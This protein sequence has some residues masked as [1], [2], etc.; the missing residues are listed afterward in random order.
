[1][2]VFALTMAATALIALFLDLPHLALWVGAP[3]AGAALLAGTAFGMGRWQPAWGLAAAAGCAALLGAPTLALAALGG[4]AG[5]AWGRVSR[6]SLGLTAALLLV[7]AIGAVAALA[8]D[9]AFDPHVSAGAAALALAVLPMVRL[10]PAMG[11]LVG[12]GVGISW[13]LAG[14]GGSGILAALAGAAVLVS[15]YRIPLRGLCMQVG[16]A[17][18]SASGALIA[19]EAGLA[20]SPGAPLSAMLLVGVALLSVVAR[21]G[22]HRSHALLALVVAVIAAAG[23]PLSAGAGMATLALIG[24][25]LCAPSRAPL[26]GALQALPSAPH[27]SSPWAPWAR[28][29]WHAARAALPALTQARH[30]P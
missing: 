7:G 23:A 20:G 9:R 18:G 30:E 4:A 25:A 1:M 14:F 28:R 6:P 16:L 29:Y 19:W 27:P 5:L 17:L 11:A 10:A 12:V 21:G 26:F 15:G 8:P 2:P 13:G 3:L 22:L 24:G